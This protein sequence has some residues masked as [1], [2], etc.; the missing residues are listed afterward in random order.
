MDV[1]GG[2]QP[3]FGVAYDVDGKGKL[4]LRAGVGLYQTRMRPYWALQ[5]QTQTLGAAVR[6]T[7]PTQLMQIQ[8]HG[9]WHGETLQEYVDNGGARSANILDNNFSLPY[10][11]NYT[12]VSLGKSTTNLR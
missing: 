5:D 9:G 6:I 8:H 3:R 2:M 11:I 10:S 1:V 4:V 7:N 12:V